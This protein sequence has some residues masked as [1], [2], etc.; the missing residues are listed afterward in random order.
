MKPLTFAL[1]GV[2]TSKKYFCHYID[3]FVSSECIGKLFYYDNFGAH[4]EILISGVEPSA[5]TSVKQN[6]LNNPNFAGELVF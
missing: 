5:T 4:T 6:F 2:E 1:P 3:I